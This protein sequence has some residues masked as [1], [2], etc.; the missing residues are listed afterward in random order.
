MAIN[1]TYT[2]FEDRSVQYPGKRY[3]TRP[4]SSIELCTIARTSNGQ[5]AEGVIYDQ[6]TPIVAQSFNDQLDNIK[7]AFDDADTE[8]AAK[9][10]T[11]NAGNN[12]TLTPELDGTVTIDATGGGGG[13]TYTAGD[14]IEISQQD[15]ISAIVPKNLLVGANGIAYKRPQQFNNN[16]TTMIYSSGFGY[17]IGDTNTA[18]ML[19]Y[20]PEAPALFADAENHTLVIRIN[21][22]GVLGEYIIAADL[23]SSNP[24]G[25]QIFTINNI[26]FTVGTCQISNNYLRID[27]LQVTDPNDAGTSYLVGVALYESAKVLCPIS[28]H[29]TELLQM[30]EK[31][32]VVTEHDDYLPAGNT[33][34]TFSSA[35]I[36][37]DSVIEVFTPDGTPYTAIS[38]VT[39]AVTI[40]FEARPANMDV[41]IRVS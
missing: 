12:I 9:Q 31:R 36:T 21:A 22:D 6:G 15:V 33:S 41:K 39:G 16:D 1:F 19:N 11:L 7:N 29:D 24:V 17:S 18:V 13:T 26:G 8:L 32:L 35:E 30:I 25:N 37:T 27:D 23:N 2:P 10:A 5:D 3:I 20:I 40:T 4:D 28:G 14:S 38:T 34:I